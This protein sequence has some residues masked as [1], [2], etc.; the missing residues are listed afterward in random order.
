M[1]DDRT[2]RN[3][4]LSFRFCALFLFRQAARVVAIIVPGAAAH[5]AGDVPGSPT[6][7]DRPKEYAIAP[8]TAQKIV[9]SARNYGYTMWL[10][11]LSLRALSL[12]LVHVKK[13]F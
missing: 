10:F 9:C 4:I 3:P 8:E 2:T 13:C 5:H 12:L 6:G 11:T 1:W 7:R